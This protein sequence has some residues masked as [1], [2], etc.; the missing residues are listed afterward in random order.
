MIA[1]LN[2]F[3]KNFELKKSL[4]KKDLQEDWDSYLKLKEWFKGKQIS[5]EKI[6]IYYPG[7][8]YDAISLL[9]IYD[10]VVSSKNKIVNL[11]LLDV[12]DSYNGF[13]SNFQ[14][15]APGKA[16][17]KSIRFKDK[18]FNI[19]YYI[20]DA[21]KFCPEKLKNKIDIYYE[22]GF[23]IVRGNNKKFFQKTDSLMK[24]GSLMITD[25]GFNKNN[26]KNF[27]KLEKIP[28]NF[29]LYKKFQ[30]WQKRM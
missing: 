24:K 20:E 6:T 17:K 1:R 18:I 29:G 26:M 11:I 15:Y 3:L 23:H 25:F 5:K 30:I 22:R 13:I 27:K 21:M 14:R 9:A 16:K 4:I 8:A 2:P 28:S 12:R 7:C 19:S 10:A